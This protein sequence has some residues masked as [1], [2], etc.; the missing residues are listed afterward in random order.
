MLEPKRMMQFTIVD[1]I[2]RKINFTKTNNIFDKLEFQ[3]NDEGE[4]LAYNEMLVDVKLMDEN[5]FVNKYLG[6]IRMLTVQF[7]NKVISDER[8]TEKMSGYNNAI[9]SILRCINPIYEFDING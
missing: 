5:E 1:I 9:V 2:E 8:E 4:L 6:I 7:E 3:Y